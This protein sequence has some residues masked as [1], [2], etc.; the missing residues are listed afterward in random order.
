MPIDLSAVNWVFVGLMAALAFVA[1]LLGSLIAF[2]NRF[3][4]AI[5]AGVLFAAGFVAWNYYPHSF[6]LPII[7]TIGMD[8][9]A[10]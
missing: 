7:K 4:G 1:A 6:G 9:S 3:V 8:T 10:G 5:I 2:R